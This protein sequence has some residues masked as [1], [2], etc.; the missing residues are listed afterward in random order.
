MRM[1]YMYYLLKESLAD[2]DEV[3]VSDGKRG[4]TPFKRIN[5]YS[6]LI[7]VLDTLHSLNICDDTI[8]D[9]MTHL[10]LI[11]K[12]NSEHAEINYT[13][14]TAIEN[15][16]KEI[17]H[18]ISTIITFLENSGVG[19]ERA[20][21]DVKMPPTHDFNEFVGYLND[22]Q[23]LVLACPY[24]RIE[25]EK[26]TIECTDIGSIWVC[27][28]VTAG[29][30]VFFSNLS[31]IIDQ[32]VKI[33]SHVITYQQQ[34][35]QLRMMKQ[36]ND[37]TDKIIEV[38]NAYTELLLNQ[39]ADELEELIGKTKDGAEREQVRKAVQSLGEMMAKGME[40]HASI[41]TPSEIKDL[42]P[43][44]NGLESLPTPIKLLSNQNKTEDT[45]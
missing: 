14:G 5:N 35:E 6:I 3:V 34:K 22:F 17:K 10:T 25:N 8:N 24:L 13:D 27:F 9:I 26:V 38:Y 45:D 42:F 43:T 28:G 1:S 33:K 36:K 4:N 11:N 30:T 37:V 31:K 23:K 44:S 18:D 19:K 39:S 21:F 2:L 20:G 41:D 12:L 29:A 7:E 16:I 15:D 32:A 40:I